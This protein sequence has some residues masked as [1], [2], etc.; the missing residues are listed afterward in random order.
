[1]QNRSQ[2]QPPSWLGGHV[3]AQTDNC[4]GCATGMRVHRGPAVGRF[5]LH[6][7]APMRHFL[8]IW[9]QRARTRDE[10]ASERTQNAQAPPPRWAGAPI[11]VFCRG[12]EVPPAII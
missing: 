8:F 11:R 9:V 2:P 7:L 1:M 3:N 4:P 12:T 6:L 5:D 10:S